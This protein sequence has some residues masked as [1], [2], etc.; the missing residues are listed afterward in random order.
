MSTYRYR[1]P[2]QRYAGGLTLRQFFAIACLFWAYVALS[3]VL[4]AYGMSTG[5]AHMT[6]G[7]PFAP[8]DARVLQHLLLLPFLLVS[9]WASLRIQWRPL[10][11]AIPLQII[12]AM[13]FAAL[14]Y[15]AMIVAELTISGGASWHEEMAHTGKDSYFLSLWLASFVSF[16]PTYGFGLALVTG[17]ALYTRFRDSELRRTALER[18]WSAARL[19]ALRMQLSPHTLFNLLHTIRGYIEW[20]PKGAQA[21]VVQLADL[22]RRLLSAGE[23]D[24]ARLGDE[25]QFVRLYLELQQRR[26]ADRLTVILPPPEDLFEAWVPSLILQPLVEN[27]VVHGLAGHQGPVTVR[28]AVEKAPGTIV[29]RVSNTIAA[30]KPPSTDGI[31]LKNVRERLAVQFSGRAGLIAGPQAEE[32]ISEIT[33]PE[34]KDSPDRR[35]VRRPASLV[36]A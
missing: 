20:D 34:I 32:W 28:V 5:I 11:V 9:Y 6:T 2:K 22:L 24:F 35:G 21:M 4:Y 13:V 3:N 18:E 14:A 25:L 36:S 27:A 15:P 17:L 29:L 23:Q 33:L 1:D 26:F 7:S 30:G 8:W 19:A 12:L 31:G 16:L 10:L